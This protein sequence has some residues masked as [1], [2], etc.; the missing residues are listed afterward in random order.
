MKK[1]P[2]RSS[3]RGGHMSWNT[4]AAHIGTVDWQVYR[5]RSTGGIHTLGLF[6]GLGNH[7]N[8]SRRDPEYHRIFITYVFLSVMSGVFIVFVL[9]NVLL[10]EQILLGVMQALLAPICIG[11]MFFLRQTR[12]VDFAAW[13]AT[14]A[15]AIFL[16]VFV[17]TS[18][19][20]S[21]TLALTAIF[22]GVAFFLLG[23]RIGAIFLA[24]FF[25]I[26]GL[27]FWWNISTSMDPV[28]SPVV[29]VNTILILVLITIQLFAYELGRKQV[30]D[31]NAKM[32]KRLEVLSSTDSLTG[33]WN[34]RT[35]D[36]FLQ[37]EVARSR[38]HGNSLSV[39]I[40]DIDHFKRVNDT[41][42]HA[43][44]D[45]VLK[46][47][48]N[49]VQDILRKYDRLGRWGGEEFLVICPETAGD[50]AV[51]LFDRLRAHV[52]GHVF[53]NGVQLTV[54]I[55]TAEYRESDSPSSLVMRADKAMYQAKQSGR[56]RV[57]TDRN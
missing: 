14:S 49:E 39:A 5:E 10:F 13:V 2:R 43:G 25:P 28:N 46:E 53:S 47:L 54:S 15:L 34:R 57:C 8:I 4:Q 36:D 30:S 56:N 6:N 33:L 37:Q 31:E 41:Y 21:S 35:T 23:H 32:L 11:T 16:M 38:R 24:F 9:V 22:P 27:M 18:E 48:S 55:G 3:H 42:G 52:A 7:L 50:V 12:N 44:G 20:H 40:I 1:L 29:F 17:L 19:A 51:A 45:I 26:I